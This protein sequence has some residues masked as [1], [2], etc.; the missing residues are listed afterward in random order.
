MILEII[1]FLACCRLETCQKY[2]LFFETR[3]KQYGKEWLII[4]TKSSLYLRRIIISAIFLS[5]A[6]VLKTAFSF[7]IP[8]FGQNGMRI[9]ISSIFSIMPSILF[10]P[11]FGMLVSGLSD[12]LGFFLKPT[13]AYMPLMTLIVAAGGFIRGGLWL[14]M[15]NG[16]SAKM[17]I[18]VGVISLLLLAF[19]IFNIVFLNADGIDKQFYDTVSTESINTDNMHFVSRMLITRTISTSDPSGNLAT[20]IVSM[21]AGLIGSAVFGIILLFTD[22]FICKRFYKNMQKGKIMQLLIVM[23]V[24]G[25]IVTTLNTVLL[26]ETIFES[27]KALPFVVVWIP[28]VIEE[29]LSNTIKAYFVAFLLGVFENQQSLHS[30]VSTKFSASRLHFP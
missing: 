24:S 11:V 20:F 4:L 7:Y 17:R 18:S 13:G 2:N 12:L 8:M 19:G 9:D 14:I 1:R 25:L 15:R 21:T 30:L 26:R 23:I 22:F 3:Q 6:L 16:S 29:V 27:W 28:R 5:I 10:G